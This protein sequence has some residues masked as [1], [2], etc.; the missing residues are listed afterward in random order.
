MGK[1]N[2]CEKCPYYSNHVSYWDGEFTEYCGAGLNPEDG[3]KHNR[4]VRWVLFKIQQRK[5]KKYD[6]YLMR[7]LEQGEQDEV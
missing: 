1:W 2:D 4:L 7:L 6:K 3:C 5:D